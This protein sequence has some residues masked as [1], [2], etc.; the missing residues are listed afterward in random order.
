MG[1]KP[2]ARKDFERLFAEDS[3]YENVRERVEGLYKG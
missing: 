3:S 1:K 2:Q